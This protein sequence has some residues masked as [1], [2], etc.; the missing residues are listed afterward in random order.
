[1]EAL[2]MLLIA[3]H[4]ILV[5]ELITRNTEEDSVDSKENGI[6]NKNKNK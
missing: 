3:I 5:V 1:M 4:T 2:I 6:D